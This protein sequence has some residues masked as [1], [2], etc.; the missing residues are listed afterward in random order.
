MIKAIDLYHVFLLGKLFLKKKCDMMTRTK[1]KIALFGRI[2]RKQFMYCPKCGKENREGLNFCTKCGTKLEKVICTPEIVSEHIKPK[3]KKNK[4]AKLLLVLMGCIALILVATWGVKEYFDNR[5]EEL[6]SSEDIEDE[7]EFD[8]D[9]EESKEDEKDN[10]QV[11]EEDEEDNG[12]EEVIVKY[13]DYYVNADSESML[14]L[15]YPDALKP[16]FF[17]TYEYAYEEE[18]EE[19]LEGELDKEELFNSLNEGF[20]EEYSSLEGF[21]WYILAIEN[22]NKLK[23]LDDEFY[24]WT[25]AEDLESFKECME[26]DYEEYDFDAQ[27]ITDAYYVEIELRA[28][29]QGEKVKMREPDV[30]YKYK[31]EWYI[32]HGFHALYYSFFDVY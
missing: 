15:V 19:E 3:V 11:R 1:C 12:Y 32:L 13:M 7:D 2:R 6:S 9:E 26:E 28:K 20:K 27:Y 4:I 23:K 22:V 18:M 5:D 29:I 31:D 30:I 24:E 17:E 16:V 25:G 10:I 8:G 21:E 14:N